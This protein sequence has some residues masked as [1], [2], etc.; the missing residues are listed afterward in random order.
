MK[1]A[2]I[3]HTEH[4]KLTDGTIVGW[5]P[6][7]LELNHLL[8]IFDTI[9]HIAVL[10][11]KNAP[12]SALPYTSDKIQLVPIK[13]VGGKKLIDKFEILTQCS[14]VV[15]T[16]DQVLKKV[17]V[18]QL[19]VPTGMGVYLIPYLTF[20]SKK[21]G[22]YKYAGNWKQENPSFSYFLQRWM[23]KKQRRKVTINGQWSH[24]LNHCITFEN[25]C[26]D[27]KSRG[28]LHEVIQR[29]NKIEKLIF[30]FVGE[31][32]TK[33]GVDLILESLNKMGENRMD[34][35]H[36]I[37]VGEKLA[38]YKKNIKNSI[39]KTIFHG[40]LSKSAVIE[41][42][43]KSHFIV[44]PS[45]SEGF[46]KVIGEAMNFGC[47]P[48]VSDV[49]CIGQYI[50]HGKNG[51]LLNPI[52]SSELLINF[53]NCMELNLSD[54][55]EINKRNFILAIKFTYAYYNKQLKEKILC[56]E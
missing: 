23:L 2:I 27:T 16:V 26:I 40:S 4:Y 33:K 46:P 37:G 28:D 41:I 21:K 45:V 20:F 50:E 44:L 17:D 35:F 8:D 34:E 10:T 29:K 42:Y 14:K 32:N 6:T 18:F 25:P 53:K 12:K 56:I 55:E 36:F 48:I 5:G 49:S 54:I 43:K 47:I 30:C 11:N 24:Q 1:L 19:R 3:S 7:V 31:L 51:F 39:I 52:S 9:F 38:Y 15:K 22:W 13:K